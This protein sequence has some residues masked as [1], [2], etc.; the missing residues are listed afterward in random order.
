LAGSF[1]RDYIRH[2]RPGVSIQRPGLCTL[3]GGARWVKTLLPKSHLKGLCSEATTRVRP[4]Q[5]AYKTS[6][7]GC[8]ERKRLQRRLGKKRPGTAQPFGA[9]RPPGRPSLVGATVLSFRCDPAACPFVF[10]CLAAGVPVVCRC[11]S[12][13]VA[14][15]FPVLLLCRCCPFVCVVASVCPGPF[16]TFGSISFVQVD[17]ALGYFRKTGGGELHLHGIQQGHPCY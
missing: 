4:V 6:P 5:C 12:S 3:E 13:A 14:G 8:C 15:R 10:C 7:A 17:G 1:L 16:W 11:L 9:V 2:R